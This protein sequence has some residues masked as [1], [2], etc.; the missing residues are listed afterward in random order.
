M[1]RRIPLTKGAFALVDDEDYDGFSR[2]RWHLQSAGYAARSS[3]RPCRGY[4]L[5]HRQILGAPDHLEV[6]HLNRTRLDNQKTNLRLCTRTQNAVNLPALGGHGSKYK[7]VCWDKSRK[8]Q[9][10]MAKMSIGNR[11]VHIGRFVTEVDAA[12]AYDHRARRVR[13]QFASLNFPKTNEI[14]ALCA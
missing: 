12:M 11:T 5:M 8:N 7:G 2:H 10:W 3:P 14:G 4:I 13:G 6:D 9:P 1:P